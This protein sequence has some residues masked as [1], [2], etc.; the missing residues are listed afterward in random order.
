MIKNKHWM[1]GVMA[2]IVILI[3]FFALFLTHLL[4]ASISEPLISKVL[5]SMLIIGPVSFLMGMPFPVGL[6]L[7]GRSS[8]QLIPWAWGINGC[9]SVISTALATIIAVES[10][11][12]FVMLM[13]AVAYFLTL[14]I[15][16]RV[17]W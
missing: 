3:L 2:M 1:A 12:G 8:A 6:R 11:F 13:A 17:K 16:I 7:L 5:V 15:N 14:L 9:F 4:R 10:G